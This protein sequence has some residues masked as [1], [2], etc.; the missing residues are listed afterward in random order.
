MRWKASDSYKYRATV[1]SKYLHTLAQTH[2]DV[3][4]TNPP[5]NQ[6]SNLEAYKNVAI[7]FPHQLSPSGKC[8]SEIS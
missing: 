6:P 1:V 3:E 8:G 7:P 4:L 5:T 2:I